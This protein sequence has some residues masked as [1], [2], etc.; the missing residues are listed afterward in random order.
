[1]SQE[2]MSGKNDIGA[3]LR[4]A[5]LHGCET[6]WKQCG[7]PKAKNNSKKGL[8]DRCVPDD[9]LLLFDLCNWCSLPTGC[10]RFGI[11]EDGS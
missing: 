6:K 1:M 9:M 2:A 3:K 8:I 11:P 4:F 5:A 7:A 10:C